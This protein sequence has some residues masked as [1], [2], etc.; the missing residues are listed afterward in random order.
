MGIDC[1]RVMLRLSLTAFAQRKRRYG[2][3]VGI[4]SESIRGILAQALAESAN[5]EPLA[6]VAS[7][8]RLRVLGWRPR[9]HIVVKSFASEAELL[10]AVDVSCHMPQPYKNEVVLAELGC[11]HLHFVPMADL[12]MSPYHCHLAD[13]TPREEYPQAMASDLLHAADVLRLFEDGYL[14][15]VRWLESGGI[16]RDA[17][18]RVDRDLHHMPI[19]SFRAMVVDGVTWALTIKDEH[20]NDHSKQSTWRSSVWGQEPY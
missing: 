17:E 1:A 14:D 11:S 3:C 16:S 19:P 9:P 12:V 5:D 6:R 7:S 10:D 13:V 8:G 2:G 4:F 15:T 18:R 20:P